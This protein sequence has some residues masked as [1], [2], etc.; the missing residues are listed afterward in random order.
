MY[1]VNLH[2]CIR[3]LYYYFIEYIIIIEYNKLKYL[4]LQPC[5]VYMYIYILI[6][7]LHIQYSYYLMNT[8]LI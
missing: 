5:G 8:D 1:C 7:A 6:Y 3:I 2:P 4:I